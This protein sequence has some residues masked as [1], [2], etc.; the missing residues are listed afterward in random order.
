MRKKKKVCAEQMPTLWD[1][2]QVDTPTEQAPILPQQPELEI[3]YCPAPGIGP[4]LSYYMEEKPVAKEV[5]IPAPVPPIKLEE[6]DDFLP[7]WERTFTE[8]QEANKWKLWKLQNTLYKD[9]YQSITREQ[10]KAKYKIY[11]YKL[12]TIIAAV[13]RLA[14]RLTTEE[15]SEMKDRHAVNVF[16]YE[17]MCQ[18]GVECILY[19]LECIHL[20]KLATANAGTLPAQLDT[21]I[22]EEVAYCIVKEFAYEEI[23][24]MPVAQLLHI[25]LPAYTKT[26]ETACYQKG[27]FWY[28]KEIEPH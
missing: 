5:A 28:A 18:M 27:A 14:I 22:A 19:R 8:D 11:G 17:Y 13:E 3:R 25:F 20:G 4:Q 6:T 1:Q 2:P 10:E 21:A 16:T 9:L 12:R 26:V 24:D 7:K 15:V 23:H